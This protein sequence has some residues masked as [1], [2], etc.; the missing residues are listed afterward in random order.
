MNRQ[1]P[2]EILLTVSHILA[3]ITEPYY[4]IR[5]REKKEKKKNTFKCQVMK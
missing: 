3:N 1:P 5:N 2:C 4:N